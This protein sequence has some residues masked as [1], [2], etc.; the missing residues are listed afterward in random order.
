MPFDGL[1]LDG[2]GNKVFEML[3][4]EILCMIEGRC[5]LRK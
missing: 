1:L 5:N 4:G 2:V 3:C